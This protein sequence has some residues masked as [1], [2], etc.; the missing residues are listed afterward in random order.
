MGWRWHRIGQGFGDAK[1]TDVTK[2]LAALEA[3]RHAV[4]VLVCGGFQCRPVKLGDGTQ[5]ECLGRVKEAKIR[6][7][8]SFARHRLPIMKFGQKPLFHE[9]DNQY[10]YFR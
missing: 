4:R 9:L 1:S 3:I 8:Q 7:E 2:H 10:V 6:G 5:T